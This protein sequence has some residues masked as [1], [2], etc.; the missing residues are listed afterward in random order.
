VLSLILSVLVGG[1]VGCALGYFGQC[2]SGTCPLTSTWW[3]GALYGAGM[4]LLFGLTSQR[5]GSS[6]ASQPDLNVKQISPEAFET[7]VVGATMPVVVGFFAPWCGPCKAMAPV[8]DALAGQFTNQVKFVKVNVDEAPALAQRFEVR[9]VP[10]IMFFRTGKPV[11]TLVGLTSAAAIRQRLELL[12]G[13]MSAAA[14][15][16]P[17]Q[18]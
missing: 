14:A 7:E 6:R 5:T 3:R 16:V 11:E 1:G 12:A 4:G 2:S 15:S 8:L 18:D 17:A 9:G 13:K 10:T